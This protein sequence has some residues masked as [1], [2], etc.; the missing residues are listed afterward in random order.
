MP[1]MAFCAVKPTGSLAGAK[2][3]TWGLFKKE[4]SVWDPCK[5]ISQELA[6]IDD[7]GCASFAKGLGMI[8]IGSGTNP[9]ART[10]PAFTATYS[11]MT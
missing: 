1:A 11:E 5:P 9:S 2:I 10:I 6:Y 4:Q 3:V 8:V 7:W